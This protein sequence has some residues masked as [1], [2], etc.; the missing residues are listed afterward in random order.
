M[1][2]VKKKKKTVLIESVRRKEI[3]VVVLI[4]L[5]LIGTIMSINFF[6]MP[7]LIKFY[8][9][10]A[11]RIMSLAAA[12]TVIVLASRQLPR[13][14]EKRTIYPLLA[15]PVGRGT[16]L[17]GKFLGVILAAAFCFGIFMSIFIGGTIYL[18]VAIPWVHL[19][20]Y[21]YLQMWAMAIL[22]LLGFFLSLLL[23]LDAAITMGIIFYLTANILTE[24][25]SF[26]YDFMGGFGKAV[27]II[28]NYSIPQLS[29]LD[30]SEKTVHAEIWQPLP[31][32]L[33]FYLTLYAFAFAAL[34]FF[35]TL[36][37]FRRR[38]L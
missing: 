22:T 6:D 18:G 17:L 9:E 34:Y 11:L 24:G 36:L 1:R 28:L 20:Q 35:L 21:F 37:L 2:N 30:F 38:E 33:L 13:E 15:K 31:P 3:Y 10:T 25:I 14:F 32:L 7:G 23:N 16:F 12:V 27:V 5:I 19:I 29:I 8:R 4:S 26:I